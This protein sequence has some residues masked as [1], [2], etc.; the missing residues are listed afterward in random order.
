MDHGLGSEQD[1][2]S[3]LTTSNIGVDDLS[4]LVL[5]SINKKKIIQEVKPSTSLITDDQPNTTSSS[6]R[7]TEFFDSYRTL[8]TQASQRV[9]KGLD[10][11]LPALFGEGRAH[12]AVSFDSQSQS[13]SSS[14]MSFHN[15]SSSPVSSLRFPTFSSSTSSSTTTNSSYASSKEDLSVKTCACVVYKYLWC[16]STI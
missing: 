3:T 15:T 9:R 7:T 11:S 6:S 5:P 14:S 1:I 16:V 2:S 13:S 10:L 4:L 8:M 12:A